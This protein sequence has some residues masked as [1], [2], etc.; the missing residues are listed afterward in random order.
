ML[1]ASILNTKEGLLNRARSLLLSQNTRCGEATALRA[2][3]FIFSLNLQEQ[4]I[5]QRVK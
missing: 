5:A 1:A 4:A 2:S 3:R